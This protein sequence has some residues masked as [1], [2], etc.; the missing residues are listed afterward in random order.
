MQLPG[1]CKGRTDSIW[2][3]NSGGTW[4]RDPPT[5]RAFG[6]ISTP[7]CA[8]AL[9]SGLGCPSFPRTLPSGDKGE[10]RERERETGSQGG[11]VCY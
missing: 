10:Q 2:E 11:Q 1:V 3:G 4:W 5:P 9:G 7:C 6:L 8:L